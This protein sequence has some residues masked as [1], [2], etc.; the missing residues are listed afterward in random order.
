MAVIFDVGK[1]LFQWDLRVLFRTLTDDAAEVERLATEVMPVTW[2]DQVDRG[3]RLAD[4]V[5]EHIALFPDDADAIRTYAARFPESLFAPVPGVPDLVERLAMAGI[6]LFAITNFGHE[7]WGQMRPT[8]PIFDHFRDIVVSGTVGLSKPDPAI[9]RLAIDRFGIDPAESLFIDDNAD[10]CAASDSVG[11][12][13]H[14]FTDAA[15]LEQELVAR[16]FLPR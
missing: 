15:T 6:P 16:G 13:A 3:R 5:A 12:P 9:F 2:H 4:M 10:N 8:R 14:H 1:V 11:L 7:F